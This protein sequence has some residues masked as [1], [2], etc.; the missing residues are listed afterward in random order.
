E[1]AAEA[2]RARFLSLWLDAVY[3]GAPALRQFATDK[4]ERL[5]ERVRDLDRRAVA[6]AAGRIRTLQLSRPDRP[7]MVTGEAPGSSELGTLLRE[8]NKKRRHLPLRQLFAAVP[9]LL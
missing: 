8:A 2:F 6:S 7:R 9:N 3:E 5:I 1:E 4:H